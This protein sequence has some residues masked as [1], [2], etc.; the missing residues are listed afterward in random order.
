MLIDFHEKNRSHLTQSQ[1]LGVNQ[2]LNLLVDKER[3]SLSAQSLAVASGMQ[4]TIVASCLRNKAALD[5]ANTSLLLTT[6]ANSKL[7][8][9]T[10]LISTTDLKNLETHIKINLA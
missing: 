5:V 3:G 9:E 6:V 2:R 4:A 1:L 7:E 10:V 8:Q